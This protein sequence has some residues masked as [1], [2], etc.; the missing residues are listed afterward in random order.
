MKQYAMNWMG[1]KKREMNDPSETR[2]LYACVCTMPGGVEI[3][4][5]VC[6]ETPA[7]SSVFLF[8][9][10]P[11]LSSRADIRMKLQIKKLNSSA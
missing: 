5:R 2:Y 3:K 1:L 8:R 11:S 6:L 4:V 10:R 7:F 9:S